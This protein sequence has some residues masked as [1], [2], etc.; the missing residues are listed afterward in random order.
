M[1]VSSSVSSPAGCDASK[2]APQVAG[3]FQQGFGAAN[4]IIEHE[5]PPERRTQN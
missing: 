3:P 5:G 2:I 4:Q 1:R